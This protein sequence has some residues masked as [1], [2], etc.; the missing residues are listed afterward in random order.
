MA[1]NQLLLVLGKPVPHEFGLQGSF[2]VALL[3]F[4]MEV[5]P[6]DLVAGALFFRSGQ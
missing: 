2:S 3:P 1:N 6:S 5:S 4:A